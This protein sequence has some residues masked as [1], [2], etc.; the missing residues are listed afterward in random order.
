MTTLHLSEIQA[1][2]QRQLDGMRVSHD[3][4]ARD[5]LLLVRTVQQMQAQLSAN[6]HEA[7]KS[8]APK[9]DSGTIGPDV[10]NFGDIFGD[11]FR[12][13]VQPGKGQK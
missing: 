10:P 5:V 6:A 9:P 13:G 2:A 3:A 7:A 4:M 11:L 8:A 12:S 1:R